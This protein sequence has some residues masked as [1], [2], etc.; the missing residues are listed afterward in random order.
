VR[1]RWHKGDIFV[2]NSREWLLVLVLFVEL[3]YVV[4]DKDVSSVLPLVKVDLPHHEFTSL[5]VRKL[6]VYIHEVY[7]PISI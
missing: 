3:K 4:N 7:K 6:V 5:L 1:R 2:C